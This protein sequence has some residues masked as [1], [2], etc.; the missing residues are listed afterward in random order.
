[1]SDWTNRLFNYFKFFDETNAKVLEALGNLG[2]RNIT[3]LAKSTN[4]P[5]TTVRFRLKKMTKDEQVL[6]SAN[7]NLSKLGLAKAFMIADA[8]LGHEK[9]L[10]ETIKNTDYW[11]YIRRCYG[12]FDGYCAYFAFPANYMKE[13]ENYMDEAKRLRAFS[14]SHFFWTTNSRVVPPNFSWYDFKRKEWTIHWEEW[15]NDVLTAPSKMSDR[16]KEPYDYPIMVDKKDLLIIKELQKDESLEFKK[17][18]KIIGIAPQSVGFRYHRHIVQRNLIADH[19]VDVYPFPIQIS[20]LY[21]FVIDFR[22]EKPVAKFTNACEKKPFV[23]SYA[24]VI[25]KNSLIVSIY[26]TKTEFPSLIKSLNR[27]YVEGSIKDFIYVTLDPTSYT[28]QTISYEYFE[29]GKWMYDP[30]EKIK[31]L[32]EIIRIY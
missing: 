10:L 25:Q 3:T 28:R 13:L 24:K 12:K 17:L 11:T 9:R 22:N 14:R 19:S 30:E 6:V 26:L 29:N 23:V 7:P 32:K 8:F 2:A 16:I 21:N 27:L 4:L 15:I 5:I 31:K 20:D 18:A 1:L